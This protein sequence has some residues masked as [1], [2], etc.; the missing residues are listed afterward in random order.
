MK[1]YNPHGVWHYAVLALAP[2]GAWRASR[3]GGY[4]I[5]YLLYG[6]TCTAMFDLEW[7]FSL[8]FWATDNDYVN[9]GIACTALP[10]GMGLLCRWIATIRLHMIA[11]ARLGKYCADCDYNL[12]GN[13]SGICPECGKVIDQDHKPSDVADASDL[14]RF[15]SPT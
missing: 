5:A 10:V 4:P 14:D 7:A 11:E 6:A 1:S 8:P 15:E 9:R 3:Y 13:V 12:R 2:L